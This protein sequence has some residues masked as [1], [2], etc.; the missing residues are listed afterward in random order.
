MAE[1]HKTLPTLCHCHSFNPFSS[2]FF[3][4]KHK[5]E[6]P[7]TISSSYH[8]QS[9]SLLVVVF[10]ISN[11]PLAMPSPFPSIHFHLSNL[12]ISLFY[13]LFSLLSEF[14]HQPHYGWRPTCFCPMKTIPNPNTTNANT[15][16][17]SPIINTTKIATHYAPT[18]FFVTPEIFFS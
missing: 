5:K 10:S 14:L 18:Y 12:N 8:C 15:I 16:T 9:I 1:Y 6:F 3:E 2:C 11:I 4:I 13:F 17:S 7:T